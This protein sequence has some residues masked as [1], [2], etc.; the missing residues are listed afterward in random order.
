[1]SIVPIPTRWHGWYFR[2]R[3]EARWAVAMSV[4]QLPFEYEP[5][6][7]RLQDGTLYLPDF[8]LPSVRMFAEAKPTFCNSLEEKKARLLAKGNGHSVLFLD[9]SPDFRAYYAATWD[10]GMYTWERYSLDIWAYKR[11]YEKQKRLFSDP[12]QRVEQDFSKEYRSAVYAS[13][14]ERF[15][16]A[17]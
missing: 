8:W 5:E 2:S 1:M 14:A 7:F 12:D 4:L 13:R 16:G 6:G 17:A 9:G 11:L 3:C 10:S 15:E